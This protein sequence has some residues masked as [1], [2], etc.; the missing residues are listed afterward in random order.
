MAD[1]GSG[2]DISIPSFLMYKQ[3]ADLFRRTLLETNQNLQIEMSFFSVDAT[4]NHSSTL[5]EIEH[6]VDEG[7]QPK[8]PVV[9]LDFW[10]SPTDW[11]S[12]EMVTKF[13]PAALAFS[14]RL[15]FNMHM[16]LVDG[17][18]LNCRAP[19]SS[20]GGKQRESALFMSQEQSDYCSTQC[21]NH[22]R[23]CSIHVSNNDFASLQNLPGSAI[24]TEALRQ[25]CIWFEPDT[26]S[27]ETLR[28][29]HTL[30]WAYVK[31][32]HKSCFSTNAFDDQGCTDQVYK[33]V[34]IS[35]ASVDS[36]ISNSGGLG[37][38]RK[39]GRGGGGDVNSILE[40]EL[41]MIRDHSI[42]ALPTLYMDG[43]P[44]NSAMTASTL[45]SVVCS[46][47]HFALPR[48]ALE[49]MLCDR[50]D[51]SVCTD[52]STCIQ[53]NGICPDGHAGLSQVGGSRSANIGETSGRISLST[54]WLSIAFILS[55]ATALS[56]LHY[57]RM[58]TELK[59]EMTSLVAEYI[60]VADSSLVRDTE[61]T[62]SS[63]ESN[64]SNS[65]PQSIELSQEDCFLQNPR[66]AMGGLPN[67]G[68][69]GTFHQEDV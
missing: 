38:P 65:V 42:Y 34:G 60:L 51:S 48:D 23:Y 2:N 20:D 55:L 4:T 43:V 36:C 61:K 39:D 59:R 32:F 18:K 27:V 31:E 3:D 37:S 13:Q 10:M 68:P 46:Q 40:K 30:W 57:R 67:G 64:H 22:G 5:E 25:L 33:K 24:V 44:H 29:K 1:D 19:S 17:V 26:K 54:F 35:H 14:N 41:D 8:Y 15:Q 11:M 53:Q 62:R 50:C 12:T 58:R 9:T 16:F 45:F 7:N 21:T 28:P 52:F 6:Q 47:F 49:R 66:D 56:L 69:L 63:M